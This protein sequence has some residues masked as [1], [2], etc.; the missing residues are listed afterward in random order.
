MLG[1][2]I[3]DGINAGPDSRAAERKFLQ[4]FRRILDTVDG[5]LDLS[6]IPAKFL[7]QSNRRSTI[8]VRPADLHDLVEGFRLLF[9]S[10]FETN[11]TWQKT[12]TD[13]YKRRYVNG[14][15]N[16]IVAR[17]PHIH[18]IIRVYLVTAASFSR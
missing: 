12:F 3:A 8:Q 2:Q 1:P 5:E 7:A 6:R 9:Q 10:A 4:A 11:Q 13:R 17:L 15:R 16:D 18:M 14:G